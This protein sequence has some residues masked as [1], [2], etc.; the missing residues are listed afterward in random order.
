MD[1]NIDIT[2]IN[3]DELKS[4]EIEKNNYQIMENIVFIVHIDAENY[5]KINEILIH[6][7]LIT[8]F[9][10]IDVV[11]FCENCSIHIEQYNF[12]FNCNNI[13]IVKSI[14][15]LN[16]IINSN[17][18]IFYS[19][20]TSIMYFSFQ[21]WLYYIRFNNIDISFLYHVNNGID[22]CGDI[23]YMNKKIILNDDHV[24]DFLKLS[25]K[26][27][28]IFNDDDYKIELFFTMKDV[29]IKT[30]F[31]LHFNNLNKLDSSNIDFNN[32]EDLK[33]L[34]YCHKV[35][36]NNYKIIFDNNIKNNE[37]LNDNLSHEILKK[38]NKNCIVIGHAGWADVISNSGM[39]RYL[40]QQFNCIYYFTYTY[41]LEI[42]KYLYKDLPNMKFIIFNVHDS[43]IYNLLNYFDKNNT[44]IVSIGH[45]NKY[46]KYIN[47]FTKV[48]NLNDIDI[49]YY[50][51]LNCVNNIEYIKHLN[52]GIMQAWECC[53]HVNIGICINYFKI[54]RDEN[55]ENIFINNIKANN[56][57]NNC[58]V[59]TNKYMKTPNNNNFD[60]TKPFMAYHDNSINVS[61]NL[62][63][64]INDKYFNIPN[65]LNLTNISDKIFD[66][67]KIFENNNLNE[68]HV[69]NSTWLFILYLLCLKYGINKNRCIYIH[70]Y[71]RKNRIEY[72]NNFKFPKLQNFV[73]I[74]N[75]N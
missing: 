48:P 39:V 71:C 36:F 23:F 2:N 32:N 43:H 55:T 72:I 65:M 56:N 51:Y 16:N 5:I 57:P 64:N 33:Y 49:E 75:I 67:I 40:Y 45:G 53:N 70:Q 29:A 52:V 8:N 30:K 11:I 24:I 46:S 28:I 54:E 61:E 50:K 66:T 14:D 47:F 18:K 26:N 27:K 31:E 25:I 20:I 9:P 42:L 34:E 37:N 7:Y 12:T 38:F 41:L 35:Y 15:E 60:I 19:S 62:N 44:H 74:N 68:I 4:R 58:I 17:D 3:I 13:R 10:F 63:G 6:D 73:E 59:N 69:I 1:L 21:N 22:I